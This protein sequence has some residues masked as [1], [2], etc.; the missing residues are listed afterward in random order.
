MIPL[1][2][3]RAGV[4]KKPRYL[5]S[6]TF[7]IGLPSSLAYQRDVWLRHT[8]LTLEMMT[9]R[10]MLLEISYLWNGNSTTSNPFEIISNG[11][12]PSGGDL[13]QNPG[14]GSN[15]TRASISNLGGPNVTKVLIIDQT[16]KFVLK[17]RVK[18]GKKTRKEGTRILFFFWGGGGQASLS[19]PYFYRVKSPSLSGIKDICLKN[20][21][22]ICLILQKG[23]KYFREIK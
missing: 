15:M 20:Y 19:K 10:F 5:N 12:M 1:S 13:E 7:S 21:F 2:D 3:S 22:K 18:K 4:N 14:M 17:K 6:S 8:T 9:V 11:E 23:G 16:D